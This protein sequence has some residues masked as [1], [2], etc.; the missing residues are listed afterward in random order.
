MVRPTIAHQ[1][2]LQSRHPFGP[3]TRKL[4]NGLSKQ[5]IQAAQW[6]D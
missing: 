5:S 1:E 6:T 2:R 4:L 3:V